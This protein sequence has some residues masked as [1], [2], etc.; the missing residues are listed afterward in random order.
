MIDVAI[1]IDLDWAPDFMIRDTMELLAGAKV[2]ATIFVT[3]S[4]D[5]LAQPDR[6]S[7]E[8]GFHLGLSDSSIETLDAA[9]GDLKSIYGPLDGVRSHA[10]LESAR[11]YPAYK[12]HSIS[13]SSNY[14]LFGAQNLRPIRMLDGIWHLP[15]Y[16]MDNV[17]LMVNDSCSYEIARQ[18]FSE[19][20]VAKGMKVFAFHPVHLYLNSADISKYEKVKHELHSEEVMAH[21][22]NKCRYGTR[23]RFH[24]LMEW[25]EKRNMKP[26]TMIEMLNQ[27]R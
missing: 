26:V 10:L 2:N 4:S 16:W 22:V 11:Y 17:H 7:C 9:I 15:I 1:S 20:L 5:L 14:L 13:Y 18:A 25:S 8:L 27:Y 21:S 3:H 19:L 24:Q 23:D 6:R 12:R